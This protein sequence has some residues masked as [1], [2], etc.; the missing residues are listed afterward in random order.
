MQKSLFIFLLSAALFLAGY[1]FYTHFQSPDFPGW[2][3]NLRDSNRNS[4]DPK[5]LKGK[6]VLVSYFQT[7][8]GDCVR[9]IPSIRLLQTKVGAEKLA[10]VFVSDETDSQIQAFQQRFGMGLQMFKTNISL[11]KL[12]IHAYPTTFLLDPSGKII[13]QKQEGFDWANDE[14]L[15]TFKTLK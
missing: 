4:F 1:R 11:K 2:E 13:I 12:G 8:C 3:M 10:V 15:E 6:Y 14:V 5:K 9:E 7:G